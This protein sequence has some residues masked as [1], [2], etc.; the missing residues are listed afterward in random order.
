MKKYIILCSL[1]FS[2]VIF[3]LIVF[4]STSNDTFKITTIK[5][6]YNLVS[7]Y[8]EEESMEVGVLVNSKK[9]HSTNT[10]YISS[11]LIESKTKGDCL[12]LELVSI[13][14]EDT[15]YVIE[16]EKY[17][18]YMFNFNIPFKTSEDFSLEIENAVLKLNYSL[19]TISLDIGSFSYYKVPYIGDKDNNISIS[20]L[21]PLVNERNKNKTLVGIQL[22]IKNEQENEI[23]IRRIVPLDLN[24]TFSPLEIKEV[25]EVYESSS[26]IKRLLGYDYVLENKEIM[27]DEI[28]LKILP[29]SQ[30]IL[31]IPI[32]YINDY[33][34]SKVGF[35]IEYECNGKKGVYYFDNFLFFTSSLINIDSLHIMTYENN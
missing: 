21:K 6:A 11:A 1:L 26:D 24:I 33:S 17:Y 12:N 5:K 19:S 27:M 34:I 3:L 30:K 7:A 22:G 32:K 31:I 8:D 14:D 10:K 16:N 18:L 29:E 2:L 28:D 15:S 9:T 13:T 23:T 35:Y 25:N 20:K 4:V